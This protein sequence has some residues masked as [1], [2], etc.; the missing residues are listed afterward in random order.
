MTSMLP[1]SL[2]L[3]RGRR[4]ALAAGVPLILGCIAWTGYNAVAWVGQGSYPVQLSL[5]VRAGTATLRIDSGTT[6]IR[7]AGGDS[8]GLTG[9]AHYALVRSVVSYQVTP[10][11]VSVTSQCRQLTGPC[12]FDYTVTVPRGL[13]TEVK[14]DSG[15]V[16]IQRLAG[17]VSVTASSGNVLLVSL[18]GAL[19]V[20]ADSGDITG[21]G[22]TAPSVLAESNSG[23]ITL[24]FT[25]VPRSV[26]V[27]ADSGTIR[28][29]LPPGAASYR[30]SDHS[31]SGGISVRVPENPA[32]QNVISASTNSGDITITH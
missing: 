27:S 28:I 5:P 22:L 23:D 3:T 24:T 9:T 8:F 31:G 4:I 11:G 6:T 15:S 16:T 2:P 7:P 12:G 18:P 17:P 13:R 21:A 29:V 32:S 30:I 26:R 14:D 19:D 25:R 1:A 20:H 10:S